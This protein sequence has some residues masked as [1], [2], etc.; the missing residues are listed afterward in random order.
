MTEACV[1]FNRCI[2]HGRDDDWSRFARDHGRRIDGIVWRL[3]PDGVHGMDKDD[4]RQEVFLRLIAGRTVHGQA[5]ANLWSYVT[6][7]IRHLLIDL[8]RKEDGRKED[9]RKQD[10]RKQDGRKQDGRRGSTGKRGSRW[11]CRPRFRELRAVGLNPEEQLLLREKIGLFLHRCGC[12]CGSRKPT[13]HL[14]RMRGRV[15]ELAYL[16]G[17]TS[18]EMAQ[19]IPGCHSAGQIDTLI[20]RLRRQLARRGVH[21]AYR[22]PHGGDASWRLALRYRSSGKPLAKSLANSLPKCR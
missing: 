16:E 5:D 9:G 14:H 11:R 2:Q 4:L 12:C 13:S 6:V 7:V 10:G 8:Y 22:H 17:R 21:L 19:L 1:L 3:A 15:L 20:Y 18:R